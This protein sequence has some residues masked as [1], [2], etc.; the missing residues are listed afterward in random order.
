MKK[1]LAILT[2]FL[3]IALFLGS[4]AWTKNQAK[5]I[6]FQ[7]Q[8]EGNPHK[9]SPEVLN[10][11]VEKAIL[12]DTNRQRQK[13][14]LGPLATQELLQKAATDHS[15]DMK[16][17][18]YLSHFS[19]E[20]KSVVDR[21][22]KYVSPLQTSVGENLHTIRS[23]EGLYDAQAIAD[24]MMSDWMKSKSHRKNILGKQFNYLGVGCVSDGREIFCTQVFSGD[25][26]SS[27]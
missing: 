5:M 13:K 22:K 15:Q 12:R 11:R 10:Q 27:R 17:R 16:R 14:G 21:V 2:G 26:L 24:L 7:L 23:G 6:P 8:Q 1:F 3:S 18:K 25:K 20:G 9:V 19:P 4:N